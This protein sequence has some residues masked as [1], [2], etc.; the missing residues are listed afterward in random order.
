[1]AGISPEMYEEFVFPFY[2]KVFDRYGLLSYGCCEAV[3]PIWE[4]CLSGVQNLRRV[5]ISPWCNEEYMGEQLR[6]RKTVYHR[7]PSPNFL[8]VGTQL[9][10]DALRLHIRKTLQAA[11]GCTLE[12][13]QRDVYSVSKSIEKVRRYVEIIRE[14]CAQ[15]WKV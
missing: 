5:S 8:G 12:F 9:D 1:M 3:D 10:E 11:R 15:H 2:K 4:K 6:G 14:E 7:K 13:T